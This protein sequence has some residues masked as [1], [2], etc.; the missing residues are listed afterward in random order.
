MSK[1]DKYFQFPLC[2]L[3]FGKTH[4]ERCN[5]ILNFSLG[6]TGLR[7]W[8]AMDEFQRDEWLDRLTN[9][10]EEPTTGIDWDEWEQQAVAYAMKLL[11]VTG[12]NVTWMLKNYR[13]VLEH[14]ERFEKM[15]GR[16]V[17]VRC[18]TGLLFE[19]RERRGMT[20]REFAVLCAINSIIGNKTVPVRIT[21]AAIAPR[22]LG[23]K[24]AK[25]LLSDQKI[26]HF[27]PAF[28]ECALTLKQ[29][30][31]TVEKLHELKWFARVTFGKRQ[32]YY[33]NRMGQEELM[34]RVFASKTHAADFRAEKAKNDNDLTAAIKSHRE[35]LAKA[36]Q[37]GQP[38]RV[39]RGN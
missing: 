27:K 7:A 34:K 23:F 31:T 11:N 26:R 37:R 4:E 17:N 16:D 20:Y 1:D 8:A 28:K 14:K 21:L 6:D 5:G 18:R 38:M 30:R 9:H 24:S 3:T 32:T 12:G 10:K 33:S 15:H 29:V 36:A 19:V 39:V 13:Q 22:S 35:R 25:A 2:A